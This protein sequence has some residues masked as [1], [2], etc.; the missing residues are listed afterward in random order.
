M[1]CG[2][3]VDSKEIEVNYLIVDT[4]SPYNIILGR[5]IANSLGAIISTK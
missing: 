4:L 2:V 1:T 3:G 5:P